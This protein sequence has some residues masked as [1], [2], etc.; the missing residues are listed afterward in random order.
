M[1]C[2]FLITTSQ[3]LFK[4][5]G[6]SFLI[7]VWIVLFPLDLARWPLLRACLYIDFNIIYNKFCS[8]KELLK[9]TLYMKIRE[10]FCNILVLLVSNLKWEI[11]TTQ[12]KMISSIL[13]ALQCICINANMYL[14]FW[15][16]DFKCELIFRIKFLD[17]IWVALP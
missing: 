8:C 17:T 15:A 11:T 3:Y 1:R 9:S 10:C 5:S 7:F 6:H 12:C 4:E 13:T 2:V 14:L 16:L